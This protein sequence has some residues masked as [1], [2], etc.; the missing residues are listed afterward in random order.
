MFDKL[1][2]LYFAYVSV[3]GRIHSNYWHSVCV[4]F[5]AIEFSFQPNRFQL[6]HIFH[7]IF[8]RTH[9]NTSNLRIKCVQYFFAWVCVCV[10]ACVYAHRTYSILPATH[11]P[12]F[13]RIFSIIFWRVVVTFTCLWSMFALP[14]STHHIPITWRT[15]F[16]NTLLFF[17]VYWFRFASC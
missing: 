11:H 6:L 14:F 15:P 3:I 4:Y 2:N 1:V 13:V 10:G 9:A 12:M 5:M 8:A 17:T 16:S 7:I